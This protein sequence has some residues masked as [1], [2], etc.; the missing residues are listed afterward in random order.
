MDSSPFPR[1]AIGAVIYNDKGE[2]L[3]AQAAKWSNR[4]LVPGGHVEYGESF[5]DTVRREVKEETALDVADIE[6]LGID[7]NIFP[8]EFKEKRH[9]IFLNFC[10]RALP[11]ILKANEELQNLEWFSV[12]KGLELDL[13]P[14][15][16]RMIEAFAEKKIK[17]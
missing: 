2:I 5:V 16:R 12:K 11:G 4:W 6:F 8:K 7:Q 17:N 13:M 10:C 1:V 9:F 14:S 15:V 3:L